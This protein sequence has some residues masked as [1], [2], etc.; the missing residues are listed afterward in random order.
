MRIPAFAFALMFSASAMALPIAPV[1]AGGALLGI[2]LFSSGCNDKKDEIARLKAKIKELEIQNQ[3]MSIEL[4]EC[5]SEVSDLELD[6]STLENTIEL[7]E[8]S[9]NECDE[10]YSYLEKDY[11]SLE[12]DLRKVHALSM[13]ISPYCDGTA[14]SSV[15]QAVR[16]EIALHMRSSV[17]NQILYQS[18]SY[19]L[20]NEVF[21]A[22]FPDSE[23]HGNFVKLRPQW[24]DSDLYYT[25]QDLIADG[26]I[27]QLHFVVKE[28]R[29]RSIMKPDLDLSLDYFKKAQ[30]RELEIYLNPKLRMNGYTG[31]DI[32]DCITIEFESIDSIL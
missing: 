5:E 11:L 6:I 23:Y 7:L 10:D 30:E 21:K 18:E 17:I 32:K 8:Y 22:S 15:S 24:E 27:S 1:V 31:P 4:S 2:S 28:N 16:D 25:I 14:P 19:L 20:V 13:Q 12:S 29:E 9:A 3:S 26:H